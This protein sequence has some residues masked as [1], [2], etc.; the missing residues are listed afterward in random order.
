MRPIGPSQPH[1]TI[2]NTPCAVSVISFLLGGVFFFSVLLFFSKLGGL[3]QTVQE[4]WWWATSQLGFFLAAWSA[5][6]WAEFAVTAGWNREKCSID[7]FLLDNGMLYHI[8][9]GTALTEYFLGLYFRPAWKAFPFVSIV[10]IIV[11]LIGQALRSCAMIHAST[12]FSHIVAVKKAER[13]ELVTDGVYGWF[14]HPSY[15]GFYYWALG[16]QLVLQN[17]VSFIMYSALLWRFFSIRIR[18]EFSGASAVWEAALIRFFG[19]DYVQYKKKVGTKI[20]FVP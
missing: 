14:R 9:H 4:G 15:T 16:T 19:E 12:N 6:H 11:T 13:H 10:G 7:S 17:P 2:P 18:C 20:P 1:G 3:A 8:A 5:F